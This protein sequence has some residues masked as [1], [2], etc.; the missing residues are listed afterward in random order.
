MYDQSIK[1]SFIINNKALK[2]KVILCRKVIEMNGR[3]RADSHYRQQMSVLNSSFVFYENDCL[4]VSIMI[5]VMAIASMVYSVH[6]NSS[7]IKLSI[8]K[9]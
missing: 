6:R 5:T 1:P 3:V 8:V 4:I 7:P 9:Q 2:A